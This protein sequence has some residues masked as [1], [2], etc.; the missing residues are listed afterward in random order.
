MNSQFNHVPVTLCKCL[1]V[2]RMPMANS[3]AWPDPTPFILNREKLLESTPEESTWCLLGTFMLVRGVGPDLQDLKKKLHVCVGSRKLQSMAIDNN[4]GNTVQLYFELG[5]DLP[6]HANFSKEKLQLSRL[7]VESKSARQA[8]QIHLH[9]HWAVKSIVKVLLTRTTLY[10]ETFTGFPSTQETIWIEKYQGKHTTVYLTSIVR[11]GEMSLAAVLINKMEE[12]SKKVYSQ[13]FAINQTPFKNEQTLHCSGFIPEACRVLHMAKYIRYERGKMVAESHQGWG[14]FCGGWSSQHST[15]QV[16]GTQQK[17]NTTPQGTMEIGYIRQWSRRGCDFNRS[18]VDLLLYATDS[19]KHPV[20]A[21]PN[22]TSTSH[23]FIIELSPVPYLLHSKQLMCLTGMLRAG[24]TQHRMI[25][26]KSEETFSSWWVT[27]QLAQ[28]TAILAPNRMRYN[29]LTTHTQST[30]TQGMPFDYTCTAL[31]T[32]GYNLK[33]LSGSSFAINHRKR[34]SRRI[35]ATLDDELCALRG[36]GGMTGINERIFPVE[37]LSGLGV[38]LRG[39]GQS[40]GSD[41][42][43]HHV[44][45]LNSVD[46]RLDQKV[47]NLAKFSQFGQNKNKIDY[48]HVDDFCQACLPGYLML[49]GIFGASGAGTGALLSTI[50]PDDSILLYT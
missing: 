26:H 9:L 47:Q 24:T 16:L 49:L 14:P 48:K 19:D 18:E 30:L 38:V 45:L 8:D 46:Q 29:N 37:C 25:Q 5:P 28:W 13:G 36:A 50:D 31:N 44:R 27:F 33:V 39:G 1:R 32:Q 6:L 15:A 42:G 11:T 10:R 34:L 17:D 2:I 20:E 21:Q 43:Y 22:P 4:W 23:E 12:T 3:P 41:T 40:A 35:A 7:V